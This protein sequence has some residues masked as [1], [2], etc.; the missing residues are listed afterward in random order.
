MNDDFLRGKKILFIGIGFYDYESTIKK[1]LEKYGSIVDFYLEQPSYLLSGLYGKIINKL[2]YQK[3]IV[4][5]HHQKILHE[6]KVKKYDIVFVLKGENLTTDFIKDLKY[7]QKNATFIMYQWDSIE[8]VSN[9]LEMIPYF[10]RVFSFDRIDCEKY[11]KLEFRPLFFRESKDEEIFDYKY[12]L[13]FI[14]WLH[15]DRM[16]LIKKVEDICK[17]KNIKT[18]IYLFTGIKT[19]ISFL[20][21]KQ[22]QN[23]YIKPLSYHKVNDYH[24][25]AKV[26]LD[27]PHPLQNGLTMRTIEAIGANKKLITTNQDIK[28]YDFYDEDN[29]SI[30]DKEN[31]DIRNDFFDKP[32]KKVSKD[33]KN[34]YSLD[35]W[36]EDVF[37]VKGKKNL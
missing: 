5:K 6:T 24:N 26:I 20:L 15:A 14:G 27:L 11:E 21:K 33:I 1:S 37:Y 29:I 22:S 34:N 13:V 8:R 31:I 32:Y 36:I 28:N 9:A 16:E 4:K 3:N 30:L 17:I 7:Q 10:D 2:K 23:L 35:S 25:S 12:D 19:Y 18:F